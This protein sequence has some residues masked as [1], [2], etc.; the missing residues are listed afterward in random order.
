M[1][2]SQEQARNIRSSARLSLATRRRHPPRV[3]PPSPDRAVLRL[4]VMFNSFRKN[5]RRLTAEQAQALFREVIREGLRAQEVQF[6][7]TLAVR[8]RYR[9]LFEPWVR[10]QLRVA[11]DDELAI[12][13]GDLWRMALR[14]LS[15]LWTVLWIRAWV[16]RLVAALRRHP[17]DLRTGTLSDA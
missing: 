16:H 10:L 15:P 6:L 9:R 1:R 7:R 12:R 3:P 8:W 13:T 11:I 5:G 17:P 4:K 14:Q 2:A